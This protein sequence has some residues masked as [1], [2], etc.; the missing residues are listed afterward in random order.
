MIQFNLLP[1]VKLE[2]IKAKKSKHLVVM[3]AL[4]ISG[5]SLAIMIILLMTVKGF[6][7]KHIDNLS[8]D[9]QSKIS[10]LKSTPDLDKILTIQNQL[11]SLSCT[12][13]DLAANKP[14]LH[15]H[16][17][18]A[19][20]L[21]TYLPKITPAKVSFQKLDIDFTANTFKI[22]GNADALSTVNKF[23]D[24]LKFTTYTTATDPTVKQPFSNVVLTTFA[25]NTKEKDKNKVAQY[26]IDLVFDHAIFDG[27][28]TVTLNVPSIISTRSETEKPADIFQQPTTQPNK[29]GN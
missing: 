24:T 14:C 2:Y 25:L 1:E 21:F 4:I 28:Q 22:T 7:K 8:T 27:T 29:T 10:Q 12:G 11:N 23:V 9:I 20:R 19:T 6:Q 18:A 15:D 13:Q 26:E 5:A 17:P 3:S 16:K